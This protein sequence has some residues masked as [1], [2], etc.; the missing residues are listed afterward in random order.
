MSK[1]NEQEIL[2]IA[3]LAKIH[4]QTEECQ[5]LGAKLGDI[6]DLVEKMQDIDTHDIEPMTHTIY[7]NQKLREDIADNPKQRDYYQSLSQDINNGFYLVP[8]VID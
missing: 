2:H 7:Q 1:I 4:L 6:L 3:E 8:K 5:N